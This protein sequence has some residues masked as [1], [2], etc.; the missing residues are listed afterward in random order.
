MPQLGELI[1]ET[2]NDTHILTDRL[3][4]AANDRD[5]TDDER[6]RV[7]YNLLDAFEQKF[8]DRRAAIRSHWLGP[9]MMELCEKHR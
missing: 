8:H 4:E 7:I 6:A 9:R 2:V 3:T 5:K 1:E